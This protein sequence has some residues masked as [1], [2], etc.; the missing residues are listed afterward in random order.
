MANL[1]LY[2]SLSNKIALSV[3]VLRHS[4]SRGRFLLGKKFKVNILKNKKI[5]QSVRPPSGGK[6]QRVLSMYGRSVVDVWSAVNY[7]YHI[8][9]IIP[10]S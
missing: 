9:F 6:M 4:I 7:S 8:R 2:N 10:D 5:P 3:T 1:I